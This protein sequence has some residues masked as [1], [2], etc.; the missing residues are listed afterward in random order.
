MVACAASPDKQ[1]GQRIA[2]SEVPV[3][4]LEGG[5]QADQVSAGESMTGPEFMVGHVAVRRRWASAQE[6]MSGMVSRGKLA[7]LRM[8]RCWARNNAREEP[9][10]RP[11][12]P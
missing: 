4:A 8:L 10:G 5:V 11:R 7:L 6:R 9:S 3:P 2:A 1:L 12:K